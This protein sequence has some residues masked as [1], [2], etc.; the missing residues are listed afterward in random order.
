MTPNVLVL[1]ADAVALLNSTLNPTEEWFSKFA[2]YDQQGRVQSGISDGVA[3]VAS[4]FASSASR[5]LVVNLGEDNFF[6]RFTD[7]HKSEILRRI[8]L[9]ASSSFTKSVNI[10]RSWASYNLGSRYS[11]HALP[12]TAK[13]AYEDA[14][15]RIEIDRHPFGNANVYVYNCSR[16]KSDLEVSVPDKAAYERGRLAFT[17]F[18]NNR[19][20]FSSTSSLAAGAIQLSEESFFYQENKMGFSEWYRSKFTAR[21][22]E[23]V[24][25]PDDAPIRLRGAAGTGKTISLAVKLLMTAKKRLAEGKLTRFLFLTHSASTSEAIKS[26]LWSLDREGVLDSLNTTPGYGFKAIT[27][28]ELAMEGVG[29]DLEADGVLPLATDALE[30][31]RLQLELIESEVASYAKSKD[32]ILM[33]GLVSDHFRDLISGDW[34]RPEFRRLA[35]EIMNEFACV[36]DAEGVQSKVDARKRYLNGPRQAWMMPL[37]NESDRKVVLDLYDRFNQQIQEMRAISVDQVMTD[38]LNYLDSFRWNAVRKNRGFDL[39]FVD[40]LHLFNRQER[41]VLHGLTRSQEQTPGLFMAYDAKQAPSDTFMPNE[42][43]ESSSAFWGRLK[44]GGI[45]KVELDQVFRYTPQIAAFIASLDQS[46]PAFEL[47]DEWGEYS[48]KS[49]ISPAEVPSI[50][51]VKDEADMYAKVV[52]RARAIKRRGG[53]KFMMAVLCCN[54]DSFDTFSRAGIYRKLFISI[55]SRDEAGASKVDAFRFLLS[56]PEYVAGLQFDCVML[57][58]VNKA[59]IPAGAY[60]SSA[61]RKF[62]STVYLGA[63]RAKHHLEIYS[64]QSQGGPSQILDG[65]IERGT[66]QRVDW[67]DL[68]N[69]SDIAQ[70]PSPRDV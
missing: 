21:Q 16:G 14:D 36:L 8:F 44:V 51:L 15:A 26:L 61:R 39:I 37:N 64:T 4:N 30:G 59:E 52:E 45:Q 20:T 27:L 24:D 5:L 43:R 19:G 53:Q 40:E 70:V 41:M 12:L 57:L 56:T 13:R 63:S 2:T 67:P 3:V 46:F 42:E 62:I 49:N 25:S 10:P 34:T 38:F 66:L 55:A 48:V 23:F 31:R 60:S 7:Q 58:D 11:F 69:I 35:W 17:K 47:G 9:A 1:D 50:T 68:P 32:W 54:P 18:L 33:R 22:Q 6:H 28:L 65:A 29:N